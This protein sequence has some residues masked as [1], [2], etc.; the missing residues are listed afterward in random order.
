ML[1]LQRCGLANPD[2]YLLDRLRLDNRELDPTVALRE[3]LQDFDLKEQLCRRIDRPLI[4][5]ASFRST[6]PHP[7]QKLEKPAGQR[8]QSNAFVVVRRTAAC[9]CVQSDK[10]LDL[11]PKPGFE[12]IP[13]TSLAPPI[14]ARDLVYERRPD[15]IKRRGEPKQPETRR[16]AGETPAPHPESEILKPR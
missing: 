12:A 4:G 16:T 11:L 14:K 5:L 15:A 10:A 7:A 13:R 8:V 6:I 9:S 3:R 1:P 2:R